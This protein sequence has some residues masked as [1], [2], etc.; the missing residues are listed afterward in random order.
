MAST[1]LPDPRSQHKAKLLT[2][3]HYVLRRNGVTLGVKGSL[4]NMLRRS[5]G[6]PTFSAFC[7]YWHPIFGYL[8]ARYIY[9]SVRVFLPSAPAL[10][11]RFLF[12]GA[13]HDLVTMLAGGSL[14]FLFTPWFFFL[15]IGVLIGR[16]LKI[17]VSHFPWGVR[18]VT[19]VAYIGICLG[20]AIGCKILL[21]I[22]V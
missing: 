2:L 21:D 20:L 13:V 7:H 10:I 3:I 18:A 9:L 17:N 15:G 1:K 16:A 12:C 8:L 4:S 5:L 22:N 11:A 6:A 14:A 19:N